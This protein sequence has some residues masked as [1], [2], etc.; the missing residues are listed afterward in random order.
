MPASQLIPPP[1]SVSISGIAVL[2]NPRQ[3]NGSQKTL[4]FDAHVFCPV[5]ALSDGQGFWQPHGYTG[6]GTEGKGQGM[7]SRTLEKPIPLSRVRGYMP[8]VF[9]FIQF[10][11]NVLS[12]LL[13][14]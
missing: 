12:I 14:L 13:K 9:C 10:T 8:R 6:T 2:E 4:F 5:N 1:G 7:D 11:Y 3:Q